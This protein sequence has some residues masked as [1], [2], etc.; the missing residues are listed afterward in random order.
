VTERIG[1][2]EKTSRARGRNAVVRVAFQ[3]HCLRLS[4][5]LLV[6]LAAIGW[7]GPA[8]AQVEINARVDV[9]EVE[10]GDTVTYSLEASTTGGESLDD[11]RLPTP[12]GFTVVRQGASPSQMV[13]IVNGRMSEKRGITAQW[14]LR[15]DRLG[16]FSIGPASIAVGNTRKT[17]TTQRVTVVAPGSGRAKPRRPKGFDPFDPFNGGGSPLDPFKGIF[18]GDDEQSDPVGQLNADP[19]LGLDNP[20]GPVAFLHATI[21]K[22]HAVVG[23]QVT[24]NV[25]LYE[26]LRQRQGRPSDVHEATATD[27]VKRSL[28]QDETRAVHVGNAIVGGHPWSVKLVR[29]N[30]LF[31][32][33]AGRLAIS[34]MS[35]TLP[36]ARVGLRESETLYVDVSEPPVANRPVG[37]QIGD[38]GD[39]SLSA[40]TAPRTVE[41][42][43]AVGVTVELRGTGNM[44]GTLPTPE[45]AGVEFL[46]PQTR[47]SLGPVANDRFGGTR[48][49]SYVV[50][51]HK[52]GAIDLGEIRLPYWDPQARAYSVARASLGIVQVSRSTGRDAGPE[53]AEQV[54]AGMPAIRTTLEGK[55]EETFLTER[56]LYWVTLFGSPLA[57]LAVISLGDAA[58]RV[59]Q[60]RA[61]TAPSP[62]RIAR[63][64]RAEAE[65]AMKGEDGKPAVAAVL[66]ALEAELLVRTGVNVRG[67]SKDGALRELVDVGVSEDA[68]NRAIRLMS[69]C[70]DARFSPSRSALPIS[71]ARDLWAQAKD[72]FHDVGDHA[73][74]RDGS[75]VPRQSVRPDAPKDSA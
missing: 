63:E 56:P 39:F 61:N 37:Y 4:L 1:Q 28:I 19:K 24:L 64:R 40:T 14:V 74:S 58:R 32:L 26:D 60:R 62:E 34:P 49:F 25:Y 33:K 35:L 44:P 31:P 68:A 21:D 72:V 75:S 29:K 71:A 65:A 12:Q 69:A 20:R 17:G 3:R 36:Q 51:L 55:R 45:I 8:F 22:T 43:G 53:V 13:T 18:P 10:L 42:H 67:T 52:D 27:F 70:E 38:T 30:A 54:L 47:D 11:A 7:S 57:C 46:E 6:A 5:A 66:R 9:N 48:T 16:T 50:R 73:T 41:Q 2:S 15:S 23:E 59:R